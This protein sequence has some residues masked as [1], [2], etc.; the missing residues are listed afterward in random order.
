[1]LMVDTVEI[2]HVGG[3]H[4]AKHAREGD[5]TGVGTRRLVNFQPDLKAEPWALLS[6]LM[7]YMFAAIIHVDRRSFFRRNHDESPSLEP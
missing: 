4:E 2:S 1:M 7:A 5:A 3:I 6:G